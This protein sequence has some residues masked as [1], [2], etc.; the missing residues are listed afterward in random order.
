MFFDEFNTLNP[1]LDAVFLRFLEKPYRYMVEL[2]NDTYAPEAGLLVLMASNKDQAELIKVGFNPA[3][4]FRATENFFRIP[5]LRERK[6]DIAVFVLQ[7]L[8][9]R[10]ENTN[11][12]CIKNM[13][14]VS[15]EGMRLI[16]DMIW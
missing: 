13:H 2:P 1:N 8:L 9:D 11:K 14:R 16:C 12:Q 7:Q 4:V 10:K 6:E 5:P 15:T 3:V